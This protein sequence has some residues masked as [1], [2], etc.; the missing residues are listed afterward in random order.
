L[1]F[2]VERTRE[3]ESK[4]LHFRESDDNKRFTAYKSPERFVSDIYFDKPSTREIMFSAQ[5]CEIAHE[6]DILM[7]SPTEGSVNNSFPR[8]LRE[9]IFFSLPPPTT[10][11]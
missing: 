2:I 6:C 10:F 11:K 9:M 7:H 5:A 4:A 1:L 8:P 3:V